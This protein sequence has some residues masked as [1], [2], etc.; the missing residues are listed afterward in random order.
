MF[1]VIFHSYKVQ[2]KSR[3]CKKN[4]LIYVT[5]QKHFRNNIY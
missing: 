1:L 5:S 2:K 4:Y 3:V